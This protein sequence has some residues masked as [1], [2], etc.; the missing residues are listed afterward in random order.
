M[1]TNLKLAIAVLFG[2]ALGVVGTQGLYAE[3]EIKRNVLQHAD[4]TGTTT[5]E[6]YMTEITAPPG[7]SFAPHVHHGD[8]FTYV[9]E[10][11]I[12]LDV[13]GQPTKTVKA[14]DTIHVTR[15]TVHGG[16]VSSGTPAKLLAVH[17][18]DKGKPLAD[19]VK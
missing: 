18:V 16:R 12:D 10:G 5:T 14:G 9:M 11:A 19:P 4:L 15:E 3:Q 1:R 2:V 7:S 6:V 8:E 13:A 17:I